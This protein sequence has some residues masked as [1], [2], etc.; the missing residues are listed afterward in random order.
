MKTVLLPEQ[1]GCDICGKDAKY[2]AP[3]V[4]GPWAYLC[5]LCYARYAGK[6]ADKIGTKLRIQ[7][8]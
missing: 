8:V 5:N 3:T 1:P 6:S 4:M 7:E 2:D